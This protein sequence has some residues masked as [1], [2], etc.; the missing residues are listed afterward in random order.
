MVQNNIESLTGQPLMSW[1]FFQTN[2]LT[3]W[4]LFSVNIFGSGPTD[5]DVCLVQIITVSPS[6]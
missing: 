2:S 3:A 6:S 5:T 4:A 1:P